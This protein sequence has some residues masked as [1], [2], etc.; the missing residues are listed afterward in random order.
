[1]LQGET[2]IADREVVLDEEGTFGNLVAWEIAKRKCV[3]LGEYPATGSA[4]DEQRLAGALP[5]Q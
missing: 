2:E 4:D 5:S 1:V 3:T